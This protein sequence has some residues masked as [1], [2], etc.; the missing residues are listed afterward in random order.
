ML[1]RVAL[2]IILDGH[3]TGSKTTAELRELLKSSI[4]SSVDSSPLA[5]EV[6]KGKL[7]KAD[8][9]KYKADIYT[10]MEDADITIE[11]RKEIFDQV[12]RG[13]VIATLL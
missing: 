3:D 7:S 11:D 5:N 8:F 1:T 9:E 10:L 12:S 4:N 6:S 2:K 13:M